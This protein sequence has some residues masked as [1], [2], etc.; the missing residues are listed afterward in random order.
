VRNRS[1]PDASV[2]PE[3]AYPDVVEAADWLCRAFG[4]RRRLQIGRHRFQLTYGNGALVVVQLPETEKPTRAL[5]VLVMVD[6]LD[7]HFEQARMAGAE[8]TDPPADHPYGER[9]YTARDPA[10][11]HWTFSQSIADVDPEDWGGTP[12]DLT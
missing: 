2:I 7:S 1:L 8:V 4:F 11:Y 9:Q 3:I 12:F 5:S 6:D 10:G